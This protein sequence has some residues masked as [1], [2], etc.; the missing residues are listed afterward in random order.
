[1]SE[2]VELEPLDG[3]YYPV[4]EL[5]V[6]V[7]RGKGLK[8]E[9]YTLRI[10]REGSSMIVLFSSHEIAAAIKGSVGKPGFEVE[11]DPNRRVVLRS[12]F[13]R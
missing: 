13:V 12:N 10:F 11:I 7:A 3:R 2:L 6:N 9:D 1:M 8:I 5:A 4:I